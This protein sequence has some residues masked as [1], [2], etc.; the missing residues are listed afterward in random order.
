MLR[1][2]PA[3]P[4]ED[5]TKLAPGQG[6]DRRCGRPGGTF[7]DF[8]RAGRGAT[9]EAAVALKGT[10]EGASGLGMTTLARWRSRWGCDGSASCGA[11]LRRQRGWAG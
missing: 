4:A 6:R 1:W 3:Q 5:P 2:R 7:G 10:A 11:E 8:D 9:A